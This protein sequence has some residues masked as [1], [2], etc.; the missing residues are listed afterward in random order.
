M[1]GGVEGGFCAV[2][3][4]RFPS[5]IP[6]VSFGGEGGGWKNGGIMGEF[7]LRVVKNTHFVA[8]GGFACVCGEGGG[9]SDALP[10]R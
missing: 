8:R 4:C 9:I 6:G 2:S 5:S 3:L 10:P 7:G 1:G